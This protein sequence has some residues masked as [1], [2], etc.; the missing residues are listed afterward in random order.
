VLQRRSPFGMTGCSAHLP[1][2][3]SKKSGINAVY[4]HEKMHN[5][6]AFIL[7]HPFLPYNTSFNQD[8]G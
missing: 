5:E 6:N 7:L 1:D 4:A 2:A 3:Q 8:E